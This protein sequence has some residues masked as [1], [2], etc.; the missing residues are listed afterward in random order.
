M[1]PV[2]YRGRDSIAKKFS[3]F[4]LDCPVAT[5]IG[6]DVW[7]GDSAIILSG[8]TVGNGAVIGA[9]SIVTHNVPAY[10]IVAGNPAKPIRYRFDANT[11]ADLEKISWWNLEDNLLEQLAAH[12]KSPRVF[13]EEYIRLSN[14]PPRIE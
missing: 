1:S 14:R 9:G 3:A 7:I 8:V 11:I 6:N 2:F 5:T 12:I 13:I 4:D 10:C